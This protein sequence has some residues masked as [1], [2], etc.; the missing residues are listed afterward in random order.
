MLNSEP[1]LKIGS[2]LFNPINRCYFI[3]LTIVPQVNSLGRISI[4][5]LDQNGKMHSV[6]PT[7]K[8]F[9]ESLIIG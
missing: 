3:V 7:Q 5:Y 6:G 9:L 8:T 4:I 2:V 1:Q